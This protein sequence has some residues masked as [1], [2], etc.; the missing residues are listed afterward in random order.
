MLWAA[1]AGFLL[2]GLGSH[3]VHAFKLRPEE[4]TNQGEV[5]RI[6][7]GL[8]GRFGDESASF[9]IRHFTS[10]VHEAITHRIFG[11]RKPGIECGELPVATTESAPPAVIAGVRWNDNPPF[12]VDADLKQEIPECRFDFTH[13][14]LPSYS[15]CWI[16]IFRDA[17]RNAA[18]QHYRARPTGKQFALLYRVHFGDMQFLHSMASW[19]GEPAQQTKDRIMMWAEFAFRLATADIGHDVEL[20]HTGVAGMEKVFQNYAWTAERLFTAD[21]TTFRTPERIREMAFGSLL[22][23][24]QDSFSRSHVARE[25]GNGAKCEESPEHPKPGRIEGFRSFNRQDSS[26]H[27]KK[28]STDGLKAHI[29]QITPNVVEV[30]KTVLRYFR[31]GKKWGE[32]R[33][34]I[35]CL[36]VLADPEAPAGPGIEYEKK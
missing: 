9:V 5:R 12:S 36:Y 31:E 35:D 27:A 28:D 2:G 19:D 23:M 16:A 20:R 29:G 13:F 3:D 8:V 32:L 30:G 21:D 14:K 22:H 24:I 17:R 33:P 11:C 25:A 34:Y 15:S 26:E 18:R 10:P 1:V 4:T 7:S 6:E